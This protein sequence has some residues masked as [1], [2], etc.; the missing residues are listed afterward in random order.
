M[1][2]ALLPTNGNYS[3]EQ[4]LQFQ[5]T[6]NPDLD[7]DI[8]KLMYY[9]NCVNIIIQANIYHKY[10]DYL[11]P[12]IISKEEEEIILNL[13]LKYKPK[14]LVNNGVFILNQDLLP[15]NSSNEFY[16]L[17]DQRIQTKVNPNIIIECN[18]INVSQFMACNYNW[19]STYYHEPI[20]SINKKK[21]DNNNMNSNGNFPFL[22]NQQNFA[23]NDMNLDV[24][25]IDNRNN[26]NNRVQNNRNR[27][28]CNSDAIKLCMYIIVGIIVIIAV[29]IKNL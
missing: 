5:Y 24:N 20:E 22:V 19:I 18:V 25:A 8:S 3:N 17:N 12:N 10:I 15:G 9:L 13:A 23:N 4:L 21:L 27:N 16:Q 28:D 14:I 26:R 2:V 1:T 11:N 6:P 29:L 7:N